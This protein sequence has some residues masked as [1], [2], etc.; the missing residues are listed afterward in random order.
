MAHNVHNPENKSVG[1]K[2]GEW[3]ESVKETLGSSGAKAEAGKDAVSHKMQEKSS[4]IQAEV[5]RG[6]RDA[7]WEKVKDPN[8]TIGERA[9]SLGHAAMQEGSALKE[10]IKST[11]YKVGYKAN[12]EQFNTK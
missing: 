2:L 11:V 4:D 12:K 9:S 5:H 1:E 6:Q 8:M 10:D 3:T 7:E